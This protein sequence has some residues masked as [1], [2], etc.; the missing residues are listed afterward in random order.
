MTTEVELET[1]TIKKF[2]P[3]YHVILLND[4]YHTFQFVY[5]VLLTVFRKSDDD[6]RRLTLEVH[7]KGQSIIETCSKERAELYLEQVLSIKE[8]DKGSINCIMEPAN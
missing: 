3:M 8:G 2:Y 1:I 6:A 4:D 5:F 7:E